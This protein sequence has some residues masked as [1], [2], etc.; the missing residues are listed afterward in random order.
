MD[1]DEPRNHGRFSAPARE[2]ADDL[3]KQVFA[4][5]RS[6]DFDIE[7]LQQKIPIYKD[8]E[9]ELRGLL[10]DL[11]KL[12]RTHFSPEN[13]LHR[14]MLF[15]LHYAVTRW[16]EYPPLEG[17][18]WLTLGFQSTNPSNDFRGTGIPGILLPLILF[19]RFPNVSKK[20]IEASH[21]PSRPFPM[22][23]ILIVC[24]NCTI[25]TF[26]ETDLIRNSRSRDVSWNVIIWFFVGLVDSVATQWINSNWKITSDFKKLHK[27]MEDAKENC[28]NVVNDILQ[29]IDKKDKMCLYN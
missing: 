2:V 25:E 11:Y 24:V 17:E 8:S 28:F 27:I 20:I 3:E 7:N 21:L 22:M 5:C 4:S 26:C 9:P 19:T 29:T 13:A 6:C 15:A 16:S 18:L 10:E 1:G 14:K 23:L 12:M